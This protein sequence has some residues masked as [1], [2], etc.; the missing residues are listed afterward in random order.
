[1]S[2]PPDGLIETR[3]WYKNVMAVI[4]LVAAIAGGV[5]GLVQFLEAHVF[6]SHKVRTNIE[7]VV[8]RSKAMEASFD[9]VSKWNAA[10]AAVGGILADKVAKRDNLALRQFGGP[11]LGEN[12]ELVVDFAQDNEGSVANAMHG[13]RLGGE[14]TIASAL[15]E[16]TGDFND[17]DRFGPDVNK[18]I[19]VI[20]GG[21]DA[22]HDRPEDV[23]RDR[24]LDVVRGEDA[25]RISF[26]LIGAGL[27]PEEQ[28]DLTELAAETGGR[29]AFADDAAALNRAVRHAVEE[30]RA[31]A[32][33]E[34]GPP[35]RAWA[36]SAGPSGVCPARL[37]SG[38][39]TITCGCPPEAIKGSVWGSGT[40]TSDSSICRAAL[41]AGAIPHDGGE[42]TV[43]AAPGCRNYEGT[44]IRGVTSYSYGVWGR[45]FYFPEFGTG[46]CTS[47]CPRKFPGEAGPITCACPP[48]AMTGTV[49]GTAIY[50]SDSSICRAA[51]HAGA[52]PAS[53]GE[54]TVRGAPGCRK[55][56]GTKKN[57]VISSSYGSW[58][59]SYFFPEVGDGACPGA[60]ANPG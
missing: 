15:V 2:E 20:T 59:R 41:H 36:P 38:T 39:E 45:S 31:A 60:P 18:S 35:K 10:I 12:S 42:V 24:L 5:Y 34:S 13:V 29:V 1:M 23:V 9:G 44:A 11:C 57:G 48:R 6:S 55:Y 40:Y 32:D 46:E 56:E 25:I 49:W 22:C 28:A 51:L 47:T 21:V 8:D 7:I 27:T 4:A 53:G 37:A 54:V 58:G 17:P 19:I 3:K 14:T 50:T 43:R 16:A 52:V 30:E 33:E 26:R